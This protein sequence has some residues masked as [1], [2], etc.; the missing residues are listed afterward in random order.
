MESLFGHCAGLFSQQ[1][2][3]LTTFLFAGIT[4]GFTH[5]ISMCGPFVACQAT[6]VSASCSSKE[7]LIQSLDLQ[8]HLGRATTYGGLGFISAYLS[9][10]IAYSPIWPWIAASMLIIAGIMFLISSMPGCK[11][12][13]INI[14]GKLTYIRSALLGFMPCGL[15]YAALIMA[16]TTANPLLGM[17]AMWVF[18]LGTIPALLLAHY[19][20]KILT[21]NWKDIMQKIGQTIMVFNGLS[22]FVMAIKLV[23]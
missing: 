10:Q 22:L 14:S 2:F 9:K 19:G 8:Y 23:R 17:F 5:C 3:I 13:L 1:K 20:V 7:S 12:S 6:C 21:K 15:L 18:V 11:H 4:G 16:A